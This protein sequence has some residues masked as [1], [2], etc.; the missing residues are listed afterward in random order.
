MPA[1]ARASASVRERLEG[2][3]RLRFLARV[4]VETGVLQQRPDVAR[5][6]DVVAR[7]GQRE[8][9]QRGEGEE[10]DST[11]AANHGRED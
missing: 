6:V 7:P 1:R 4:A 3:S 11:D 2:E 9:R 10:R 8:G 5:E